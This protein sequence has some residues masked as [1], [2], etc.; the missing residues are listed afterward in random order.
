MTTSQLPKQVKTLYISLEINQFPAQAIV[1][2]DHRYKDKP[3]VVIRQNKN[4]HKSFV[5]ACSSQAMEMD[6]FPGTPVYNLKKQHPK[7][8]MIY[9]DKERE[10]Q[11]CRELENIFDGY[12]P[13]YEIKENGAS[14]ILDL[15]HTPLKGFS[16]AEE[17]S[18]KIK[19]EI[20]LKLNLQEVAIGISQSKL[21]A[22]LLA[23]LAKPDGVKICSPGEELVL[24]TFLDCRYLPGLSPACRAKLKKYGLKKI[25]QVQNLDKEAL[26]KRFGREGEKL[27]A[28]VQ[29]FD[30]KSKATQSLELHVETVLKKDI[31]QIPLLHRYIRHTADKLCFLLKS[32]H[33]LINKLTLV[34]TYT[35]SKTVQKTTSIP[36][37]NDLPIIIEKLLILFEDLYQR[38][39]A[40]KSLKISV[41]NPNKFDGQLMLFDTKQN[42]K[43]RLFWEGITQVRNRLNFNTLCSA[44]ALRTITPPKREFIKKKNFVGFQKDLKW[45][46]LKPPPNLT[47]K[48]IHVGTAVDHSNGK[49]LFNKNKS[50]VLEYLKVYQKLFFFVEIQYTF[51]QQ[52]LIKDFAKIERYI[53]DS[54]MVVVR[55]HKDISQSKKK[56]LRDSIKLMQNHIQA[57]APL[58]ETG[59]FYSFIIQLDHHEIRSQKMLDYLL[60]VASEALRRRIDVHIEFRHISWETEFVLQALRDNGIGICNTEQP[61]LPHILPLRH[62]ATTDKGLLRYTAPSYNVKENTDY[63]YTAEEIKERIAGQITLNQKVSS[64]AI[65]YNNTPP[66]AAINNAI[67]NIEFL[68]ET[69]L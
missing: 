43:Q 6:I 32:H 3:F 13:D 56:N 54:M 38:R 50:S 51:Y 44:A 18:N 8:I 22:K 28:L 45:R 23:R 60:Y 52:P 58:L 66:L 5:F 12:T 11:V 2:Y 19:K 15:S 17:L 67:K 14:S 31:F 69:G 55:V 61:K 21:M 20:E 34:L 24:L 48:D 36:K 9:Q 37:T 40:I 16:S 65:I 53:K 10:R 39:V 64:L 26:V 41:K 62:Y 4:S 68:K 63:S 29:G 7:L 30:L 47:S 35:D 1:V 42:Q 33:L 27:Y 59:R 57:I 25:G 46:F 49:L